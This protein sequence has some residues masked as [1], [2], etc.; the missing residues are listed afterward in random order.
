MRT[1]LILAAMAVMAILAGCGDTPGATVSDSY[2]TTNSYSTT[3]NSSS[4]S[5]Q[6]TSTDTT[7]TTTTGSNNI[8][9]TDPTVK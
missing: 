2:N 5:S 8:I 7:T 9:L 4:T 3:T 6:N 1:L